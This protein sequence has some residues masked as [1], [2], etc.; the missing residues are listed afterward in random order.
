MG[1][2]STSY[3]QDSTDYSCKIQ[4]NW[5]TVTVA[6]IIEHHG[7]HSRTPATQRW[8]T[9]LPTFESAVGGDDPHTGLLWGVIARGDL[10]HIHLYF[11]FNNLKHLC[12]IY[13]I[14]NERKTSNLQQNCLYLYK[15]KE[16]HMYWVLFVV[17]LDLRQGLIVLNSMKIKLV[18]HH[19]AICGSWGVKIIVWGVLRGWWHV[20]GDGTLWGCDPRVGVTLQLWVRPGAR[21]KS[22]SPGWLASPAMNARDTTKVCIWR[23]DTGCKIAI[24]RKGIIILRPLHRISFGPRWILSPGLDFT[25]NYDPRSSF[26]VECWPRVTIQR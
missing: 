2:D 14:P 18:Q 23:L 11:F 17:L 1:L 8:V 26:H 22:A 5:C 7:G 9:Y 4:K 25:L 3:A 12:L 10:F 15:N 24:P 21:E 19:L 20:G 13:R 6:Q 16:I